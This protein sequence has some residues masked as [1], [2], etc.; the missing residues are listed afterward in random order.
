MQMNGINEL[1]TIA[2]Y[3]RQWSD[4]PLIVLVLNNGDLNFATWERRVLAGDPRF[5]PA[6]DV[7]ELPYARYA[8][9]IGLDGIAVD[10]Q[11]QVGPAWDEALAADR[12]VVLDAR[13]DPNV[14]PHLTFK[15]AKAFFEAMLKGDADSADILRKAIGDLTA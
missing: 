5:A 15:Q 6:Q 10:A 8:E 9:L 13:T 3:W 14:P 1:I 4:P 2:K 12:P 7:P 11:D